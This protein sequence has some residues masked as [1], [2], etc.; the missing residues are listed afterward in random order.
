MT[1]VLV[2][3]D[4]AM[5]RKS[6]CA[7]LSIAGH[8][9]IDAEDGMAALE[10]LKNQTVEIAIVDVWMPGVDGLSFLRQVREDSH[11][12]PIVIIS[13]GGP[14]DTLEYA[15]ALALARGADHVLFKPFEDFELLEIVNEL[16]AS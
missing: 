6:I 16:L 12:F 8:D 10:V 2:V 13:G 9:T 11:D 15:S 4:D 3:D 5:V 7:I 1:N 14:G